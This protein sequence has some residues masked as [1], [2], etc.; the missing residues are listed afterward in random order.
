MD[1][2]LSAV[3]VA[4][5]ISNPIN[6]TIYR[7]N[8]RAE[9]IFGRLSEVTTVRELYQ[10]S[11][12]DYEW[13]SS[14]E[15]SPYTFEFRTV[16]LHR[17]ELEI[18]MDTFFCENA[19]GDMLRVDSLC[20]A[21]CQDFDL[22]YYKYELVSISQTWKYPNCRS[23]DDMINLFLKAALFIYAADRCFIFEVDPDINCVVDVFSQS[24]KMCCSALAGQC[25]GVAGKGS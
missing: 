6:E 15:V 3:D 20:R 16:I 13:Y 18:I 4:V 7:I 5:I 11:P 24:R 19:A 23:K 22:C 21:G 1:R 25:C 8:K 17:I 10:L 9:E 12:S 2:L 14:S